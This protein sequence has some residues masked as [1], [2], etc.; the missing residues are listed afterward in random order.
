M[1]SRK[2]PV[3]EARV[4]LLPELSGGRQG[5]SL[6]QY[7]P[8]IVL[9]PQLQRIAI[10]DGNYLV[11]NYLGVMFVGGPDQMDPGVT[12]EVKLALMYAPEVSYTGGGAWCY[13]HAARRAR[14]C[15]LWFGPVS[16]ARIDVFAISPRWGVVQESMS[17]IA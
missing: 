8:H 16:W 14:N 13:F 1:K 17:E 10:R 5:L 11:E 2:V 4:T 3:A 7:R 15:W 6:G 9:G 12:A